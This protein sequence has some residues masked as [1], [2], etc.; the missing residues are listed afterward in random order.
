MKETV[1]KTSTV[2]ISVSTLLKKVNEVAKLPLFHKN[3]TFHFFFV[4]K[5]MFP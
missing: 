3:Q 2:S 4:G 1:V 5:H